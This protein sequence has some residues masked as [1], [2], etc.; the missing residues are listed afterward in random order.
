MYTF[1]LI[2]LLDMIFR[3]YFQYAAVV[4]LFGVN[5]HFFLYKKNYLHEI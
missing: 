2:L 1:L 5:V 4:I 3:S